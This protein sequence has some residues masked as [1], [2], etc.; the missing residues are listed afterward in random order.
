[1]AS[2]TS[3]IA[4]SKSSASLAS[5]AGQY[6]GNSLAKPLMARV[7]SRSFVPILLDLKARKLQRHRLNREAKLFLEEDGYPSW[8]G[9]KIIPVHDKHRRKSE[10]G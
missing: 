2:F 10:I 7:V 9:K 3:G 1:M 6:R 5:S 4:Q 8:Q